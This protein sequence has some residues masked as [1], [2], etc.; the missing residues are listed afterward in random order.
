MLLYSIIAL[1]CNEQSVQPM[2][3]YG[4]TEALTLK[5][6][7]AYFSFNYGDFGHTVDIKA[8][9][10]GKEISTMYYEYNFTCPTNE[11]E[12]VE[13]EHLYDNETQTAIVG[14]NVA[15]AAN[16]DKV[17]VSVVSKVRPIAINSAMSLIY[18]LFLFF[19]INI[20]VATILQYFYFKNSMDPREYLPQEKEEQQKS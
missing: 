9:H 10:K 18:G 14:V 20:V 11:S 5:S 1:L 7:W 6:G 8:W 4:Q 16:G 2:D 17:Q 19:S 3:I 15:D 13:Y 12:K